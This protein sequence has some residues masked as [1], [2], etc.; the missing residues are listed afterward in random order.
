[1]PLSPTTIATAIAALSVS[2]VAIKDLTAVP[3]AVVHRDCPI[4]FPDAENFISLKGVDRQTLGDDSGAFKFV[5]Y[6]LHYV[7][8]HSQVGAERGLAK[9]AQD[10]ISKLYA[11]IAALIANE[12]AL[13]ATGLTPKHSQLRV[14]L[15]PSGKLSFHG[16]RID[17][18]VQ[19][20]INP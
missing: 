12:N 7:F 9:V 16:C 14:L 13:N 3:E 1:M 20:W 19:E 6:T 5:N 4:L 11:V 15:E 2:G 10:A 18:D 17:I 8:L